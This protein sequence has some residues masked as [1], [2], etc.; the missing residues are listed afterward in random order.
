MTT[1]M[2][3]GNFM[4]SLVR[5][6]LTLSLIGSTILGSWLSLSPQVLA[7]TPEEIIPILRAIPVFT[8]T[9]AQGLPLVSAW[10]DRPR[11]AEVFI[12]QQAAETLVER[13]KQ[14]KPDVGKQ[15]QVRPVSLGQIYQLARANA[16]RENGLKF[17]F[18]PVGEQFSKAQT[19]WNQ[20]RKPR[21]PEQFPGTPLFT[22]RGG[23]SQG[24][25]TITR[26]NRE[27]IP[28]F[29][30]EKPLLE[31]VERFKAQNPNQANTVRIEVVALERMIQTLQT[32]NDQQLKNIVLVPSQESLLF[33]ESL[34]Q[35]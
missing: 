25:L 27:V 1:K 24:Y 28:F 18:V 16:Q 15:A 21:D 23:Q 7:L 22:A 32:Q 4:R 13:L 35:Q 26:N 30:E 12:S 29:F 9:D 20:Q 14:E 11:V 17:A 3:E 2:S 10:Q 8:V 19:L 34:K 33:L 6:G 5:W 31:L